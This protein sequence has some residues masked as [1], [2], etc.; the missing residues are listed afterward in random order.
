MFHNNF[1]A[2]EDAVSLQTECI[3]KWKRPQKEFRELWPPNE[4]NTADTRPA[5]LTSM[6]KMALEPTEAPWPEVAMRTDE[7]K[8]SRGK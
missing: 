8:S 7:E 3:S 1:V 2:A 6:G 4:V 5:F